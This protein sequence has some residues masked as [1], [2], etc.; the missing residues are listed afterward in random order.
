MDTKK[1]AAHRH[2]QQQFNSLQFAFKNSTWWN[3]R[4]G[5][6]FAGSNTDS[7]GYGS[8]A[9]TA[10]VNTHISG[11]DQRADG[12][13]VN[14][15][16]HSTTQDGKPSDNL[17]TNN[18]AQVTRD[19]LTAA[20]GINFVNVNATTN[21]VHDTTSDHYSGNAVD[22]NEINGM[23]IAT[24]GKNLALTLE[25]QALFDTNTRYVEG[26]G[27]DWVRTAPGGQWTHARN[28]PTMN[29]HIHWST[30]RN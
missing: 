5:V 30:F 2:H 23:R 15:Y 13:Y 1:D 27:G 16:F 22:I 9:A 7:D 29:N 11:S 25:S 20:D 19:I 21:G 6:D 4:G 8:Q 26:P 17:V 12:S 18:L 3:S 10:P 28:L 14:V 24:D